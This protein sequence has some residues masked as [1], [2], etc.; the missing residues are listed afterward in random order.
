MPKRKGVKMEAGGEMKAVSGQRLYISL[1]NSWLNRGS[2][3]EHGG[4]ECI[5]WKINAHFIFYIFSF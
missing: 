1:L 2:I 4:R 5:C 3:G